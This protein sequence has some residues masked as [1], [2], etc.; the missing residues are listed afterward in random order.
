M[1]GEFLDWSTLS[2]WDVTFALLS[3]VAG[4]IA[5]RLVRRG[6]LALMA[7]LEGISAET[8]R[9]VAS[10]SGII[11]LL[12]GV[13][14]AL[15]FLGAPLQPVLAIVI[16][17]AIVALLV[18]RGIADNFSSGI[19]L[20][21]RKPVQP[22]DQVATPDYD[23]TVEE[24]T[25]RSVVVRSF[26]GRAVHIPNSAFLNN[27]FVNGSAFGANRT[28]LE[29]R[30]PLG[31]LG[32]E[33]VLAELERVA[34]SVDGVR[35]E[36]ADQAPWARAITIGADRMTARVQVWHEPGRSQATG[37]AVVVALAAALA[38]RGPD[39]LV[40]SELPSTMARTEER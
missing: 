7:R 35:T 2:A 38:D 5:S 30:T 34:A 4:W 33:A 28:E 39:V 10:I 32:V 21:T 19:V 37:G 23:G 20:Q 27:P 18:L 31:G 11:V 17:V 25:S 8:G 3:V 40:T 15:S 13:G 1:S 36:P 16:I 12:L 14:V 6:I 22:G 9:R 29:V 24:L 26:D